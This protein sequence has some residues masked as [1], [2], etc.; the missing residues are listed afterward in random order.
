MNKGN[1]GNKGVG[2]QTG[3]VSHAST[4][5]PTP[6]EEAVMGT[7]GDAPPLGEKHLGDASG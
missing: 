4:L 5:G 6:G 2:G 3:C 1:R 7:Q